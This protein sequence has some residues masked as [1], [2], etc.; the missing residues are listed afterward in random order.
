MPSLITVTKILPP[1]GGRALIALWISVKSAALQ[2]GGPKLGATTKLAAYLSVE[3]TMVVL[4]LYRR[5][6]E[7]DWSAALLEAFVL[8]EE[9][10]DERPPGLPYP[11]GQMPLMDDIRLRDPA[12]ESL[13]DLSSL[14]Y[15]RS[16][17]S[18]VRYLTTGTWPTVSAGRPPV[19]GRY[20]GGP[21]S[22]A[23]LIRGRPAHGEPRPDRLDREFAACPNSPVAP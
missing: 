15:I 4:L 9:R 1:P 19:R 18:D 11:G 3:Q 7:A 20:G 10:G 13:R 2:L 22:G 8:G 6:P 14:H 21:C 5:G 16:D 23:V 12:S 17:S